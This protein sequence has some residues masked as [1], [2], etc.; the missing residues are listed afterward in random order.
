MV[1]ILKNDLNS[2][3][4]II[5]VLLVE[6]SEHD[7][8]LI[9][10]SL[11]KEKVTFEVVEKETGQ[12]ALAY[13]KSNSSKIDIILCDFKLPGM[14]GVELCRKIK[15][16]KPGIPIVMITGYGDE[17]VVAEAFK[18]G[19]ADY[20]SKDQANYLEILPVML[21]KTL[22]EFQEHQARLTAENKLHEYHRDLEKTVKERTRELEQEI[23]KRETAEKALKKQRQSLEKL[24]DKRTEK[25][26]KSNRELIKEIEQ[27]RKAQE[28]IRISEK[29]FRELFNNMGDGVVVY[30]RSDDGKDFII[31]NMNRAGRKIS[32]VKTLKSI[33]NKKA[34]EAFP[35]L[36]DFG[37]FDVFE[38]VWQTGHPEHHPISFYSDPNQQVWVENYVFKLPSGEI[39]AVYNDFTREKEADMAFRKAHQQLRAVFDAIPGA[40]CVIDKKYQLLEVNQKFLNMFKLPNRSAAVGRCCYEVMKKDKSPC[41]LCGLD[42][43]LKEGKKFTRLTDPE[44]EKITG[45]TGKIYF[46]PILDEKNKVW[47]TVECLMDVTDLKRAQTALSRAKKAVEHAIQ[48]KSEFLSNV[49]H[50]MRS[51]LNSI[52]GFSEMLIE[53]KKLDASQIEQISIIQSCANSLLGMVNDMLD[54]S[55]IQSGDIEIAT[56]PINLKDMLSE[57][58]DQ[59]IPRMNLKKLSF[60]SYTESKLPKTIFT[61][62]I[63]L[64]QIISTLLSNAVKHTEK[65]KIE[66]TVCTEKH[67]KI[68]EA[69]KKRQPAKLLGSCRT[70][71]LK[72]TVSDTGE[73]I[74]KQQQKLIFDDFSNTFNV[75]QDPQSGGG[76]GLWVCKKLL[77]KMGGKIGLESEFGSGSAFHFTIPLLAAKE[78]RHTAVEPLKP[79]RQLNILV[80]EDDPPCRLLLQSICEQCGHTVH[81]ENDGLAAMNYFTNNRENIDLILL[82]VKLPLL[83]GLEVAGKIR[84]INIH[85]NT[86]TPIIAVTANAMPGDRE[87]C[88]NAGMDAYLAKP[89]RI[90]AISKLLEQFC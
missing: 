27:R 35:S 34:T 64:R 37:L 13:L 38:R 30:A 80:A 52:L 72:F 43:T 77:E 79:K 28:K 81:L 73:G 69:W 32:K 19:I 16:Q 88:L 11:Y 41:K 12:A 86:H 25:L 66:L 10:R 49:T 53:Q 51:P 68:T 5:R 23:K 36:R 82:D 2:E 24:V 83:N 84:E 65:G 47:G 9:R 57:I 17:S 1:P 20:I 71:N 3:S 26:R 90:P 70:V 85:D 40:I 59:F 42:L 6:N 44:E 61:D 58:C 14:D 7:R 22:H 60:Q 39:V 18:S 67:T 4:G 63:R 33:L 89:F 78:E 15:Q 56:E 21:T 50:E 45:I 62:S 31:K 74:P 75:T 46:E 55:K 76:M 54:L 8:V 48:S 29:K 87:T